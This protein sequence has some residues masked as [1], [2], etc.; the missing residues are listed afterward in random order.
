MPAWAVKKGNASL[1]AFLNGFLTAERENGEL[2]RLQEK[3]FD[4]SFDDLPLYWMTEY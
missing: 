2:A 4:K 1:W 3:W